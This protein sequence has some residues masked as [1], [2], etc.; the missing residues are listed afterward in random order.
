MPWIDD[1]LGNDLKPHWS[2][3]RYSSGGENDGVW[4]LD[5]KNSKL[6]FKPANVG[7]ESA[8]WGPWLDLKINSA[9]DII[10]ELLGRMKSSGV[11]ATGRNG[12]LCLGVNRSLYAVSNTCRYGLNAD[13]GGGTVNYFVGKANGI[14]QPQPGF[15][16]STWYTMNLTDQ[17]FR[18]KMVRT[19]GQMV[20]YVDDHLQASYP[21]TTL[22]DEITVKLVVYTTLGMDTE[23]WIDAIKVW[24][25]ECVL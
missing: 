25:D 1:F 6:Y 8:Y 10:I 9:N 15:P 22:I 20:M 14:V 12:S 17:V 2:I 5:A 21:Y 11:G 4:T 13:R 23:M 18:L 7:T 3:Y 19:G 16:A 24:P